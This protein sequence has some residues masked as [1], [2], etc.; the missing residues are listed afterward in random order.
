MKKVLYISH[1]AFLDFDYPILKRLSREVDL[2]ILV[3]FNNRTKN[4]TIFNYPGDL[5]TGIYSK[6]NVSKTQFQVFLD[7]EKISEV[8]YLFNEKTNPIL[9]KNILLQIKLIRILIKKKIRI[10]HCNE[11]IGLNL[12]L[13]HFLP[14][15]KIHLNVHDPVAHLGERFVLNEISKKI[16]LARANNLY[17]FNK[18]QFQ[19][20]QK[21]F[22]GKIKHT[23]YL[24]MGIYESYLKSDQSSLSNQKSTNE[25]LKVL[26]FGR[27]QKYKGIEILVKACKILNEADFQFQCTIAGSGK[28]NLFKEIETLNNRIK[29]INKYIETEELKELITNTDVIVCPYIDAS[30]S[31]VVMTAFA[32]KK[33]V[34]VSNVGGL[35]DMVNHKRTGLICSAGDSQILADTII[36]FTQLKDTIDFYRNINEDYFLKNPWDSF[37]KHLKELY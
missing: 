8:Y 4:M 15:I 11:Q 30:Q 2:H 31:G 36:E 25:S 17:I 22:L 33:P 29:L 12:F 5:K 13:I 35:T 28:F 21:T 19:K 26:F 3:K 9:P 32:F 18:I 1:P 23:S 34:I 7:H 16:S 24:K 20:F 14:Y 10:V 37:V 6:D 27:F